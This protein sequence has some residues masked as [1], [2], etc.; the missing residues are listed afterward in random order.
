MNFFY[1]LEDVVLISL[2]EMTK[3]KHVKVILEVFG[4]NNFEPSH[5]TGIHSKSTRTTQ[6]L[7][8]TVFNKYDS[9]TEIR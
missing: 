9:E 6:Y 3:N 7:Q 1:G 5:K 8:H 2:N 4:K